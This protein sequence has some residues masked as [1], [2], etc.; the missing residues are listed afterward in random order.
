[1]A[2]EAAELLDDDV[3]PE[4][5]DDA[6]GGDDEETDEEKLLW[7]PVADEWMLMQFSSTVKFTTASSSCFSSRRGALTRRGE[8]GTRD[9]ALGEEVELAELC[10]PH[11]VSKRLGAW[12]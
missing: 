9:G 6:D 2:A 5:S 3:P 7:S 1:L 8:L 10:G 11:E 12:S 4:A